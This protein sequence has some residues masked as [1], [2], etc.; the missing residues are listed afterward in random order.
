MSRNLIC[1]LCLFLSFTLFLAASPGELAFDMYHT[2]KEVNSLLKSWSSEYPQ[3]TKL[4]NIG[5]SSGKS[6]LLVLR[7]AAKGKGSPEPDS[8]PAIFVSANTEGV[9][10]V[11]TEAALM[12]IEAARNFFSKIRYERRTNNNPIDDDLDDLMDEDGPDDLNKDGLITKMRVKDP[13]GEWIPD[14]TDSRLMR[15]ADPKKGEKG[16][17]LKSTV[18][19]LMTLNTLL[20]LQASGPS[21]KKKQ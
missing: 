11:G 19:S 20:N 1:S 12:L 4:V 21:P 15:K 16:I 6:D 18:I 17:V 3:L 8:R 9:H 2:P 14:P 7:I 10:L 13:E 5:K